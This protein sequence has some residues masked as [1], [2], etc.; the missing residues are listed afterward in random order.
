MKTVVLFVTAAGLLL[1]VAPR[2]SSAD[3]GAAVLRVLSYNVHG[4][5]QIAAGDA[6]V[7]R[8][9]KIARLIGGR[10][11]IALLQENFEYPHLVSDNLGDAPHDHHD[12]GRNLVAAGLGQRMMQALV[13]GPSRVLFGVKVPNPSGLTT[14]TSGAGGFTTSPLVNEPYVVCEGYL[15]DKND[16]LAPKGYLGVRLSRADGLAIDVYNTHLDARSGGKSN[17]EVRRRQLAQLATAIRRHSRGRALIV[18]GDFNTG[19]QRPKDFALLKSFRTLLGLTDSVAR[20][21]PSWNGEADVDYILYRSSQATRLGLDGADGSAGE[22]GSFRW[23]DDRLR[24][25]DHPAIFARFRAEA[26]R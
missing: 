1:A 16:C 15:F 25:S 21:D 18:A 12:G 9:P 26:T 19:H 23:Q 4:L 6:P 13:L 22:D 8:L 5:P 24:L 3:G 2:L 7:E 11:D 20:R 10:Y 14:I 17:R